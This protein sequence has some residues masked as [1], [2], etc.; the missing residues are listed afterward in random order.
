VPTRLRPD[1][2]TLDV[3]A[4]DSSTVLL[5]F[6][7][8][9]VATVITTA[10]ALQQNFRSFEVFGSSGS[11]SYDGLLMAEH[12]PEVRTASI[13]ADGL[14]ILEPSTRMP[15]SGAELPKRRA[16]G[17]IRALAL[18]LEEW[19][20]AFDGQPSMAPSLQDGHRVQR[21]VDAARRSSAGAGWVMLDPAAATNVNTGAIQ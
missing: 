16:A 11:V 6:A 10:I 12:E 14:S 15:R 3:D 1:G 5:R 21:V 18:L 7:N 9:L 2:T 17:A 20:P 13:H 4:D 8:G 19:L